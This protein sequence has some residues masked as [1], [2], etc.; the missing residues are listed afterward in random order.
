MQSPSLLKLVSREPFI[1]EYIFTN[2]QRDYREVITNIVIGS[3]PSTHRKWQKMG[4]KNITYTMIRIKGKIKL[5][6]HIIRMCCVYISL[7]MSI[8]ISSPPSDLCTIFV[9]YNFTY[10][11]DTKSS[12]IFALSSKTLEKSK[13]RNP[14]N[15]MLPLFISTALHFKRLGVWLHYRTS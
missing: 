14:I 6:L 15:F 7:Y 11:W 9:H 10:A 4:C 12:I 13:M 3:C 2:T 8:H 5:K 1:C